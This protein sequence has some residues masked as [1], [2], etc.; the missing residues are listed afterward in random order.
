M[1]EPPEGLTKSVK[2]RCGAMNDIP[3]KT[4]I[5]K[6]STCGKTSAVMFFGTV[7]D[8]NRNYVNQTKVEEE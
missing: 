5:Y 4:T 2:C 3:F 8:K 1:I 6:C 7:I